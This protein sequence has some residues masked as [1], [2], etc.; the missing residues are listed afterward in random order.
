[1][2]ATVRAGDP[3]VRRR[4]AACAVTATV[5][6]LIRDHEAQGPGL[7]KPE[8]I[9]LYRGEPMVADFRI[10]QRWV[11][12]MVAVARRDSSGQAAPALAFA[13]A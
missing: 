5:A 9:L 7:E 13:P 10:H 1:M 3:H 8:N 11:R 12:F 2:T 4:T 6:R